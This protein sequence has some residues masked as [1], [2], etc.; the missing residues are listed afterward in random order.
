[1]VLGFGLA[2]VTM[3]PVLSFFLS[4]VFGFMAGIL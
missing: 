3:L 4:F 1:M 2:F